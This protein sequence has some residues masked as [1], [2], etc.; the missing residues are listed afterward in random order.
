MTKTAIIAAFLVVCAVPAQAGEPENMVSIETI[1]TDLDG[2]VSESEFVSHKTALGDVTV[3]EA[4][5]LFA[6][7][8]TDTSGMIEPKELAAVKAA[9]GNA[10]K[11]S[12]SMD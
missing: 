3:E 5:S 10:S 9:T 6:T 2:F 8:D 12:K 4:K 11:T 1:D 7:L